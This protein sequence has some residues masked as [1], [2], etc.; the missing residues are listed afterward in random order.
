LSIWT[1]FWLMAH[2]SWFIEKHNIMNASEKFNF[3]N[4]RVY[5]DALNFSK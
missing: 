4:L 2:G 3:E 1:N 5:Q